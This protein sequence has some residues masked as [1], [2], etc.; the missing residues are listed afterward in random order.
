MFRIT[1]QKDVN[2]VKTKHQPRLNVTING[3]NVQMLVDTGSNINI[4]DENT[5]E[6]FQV[7]PKLF[8]ADT[9]V[10]TYGS[11][12]NFPLLGK[13]I[14]ALETRHKITTVTIYVTKGSSGC[15]LCYDSVVVLQVIP[16]T[17]RWSHHL[18]ILRKTT[19]TI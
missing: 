11:N 9:K 7:K 17:S 3:V 19:T 1:E 18:I 15:L 12:T 14:G 13:F 4:L 6:K 8:K 16:E 10:F 2:S 5:Y